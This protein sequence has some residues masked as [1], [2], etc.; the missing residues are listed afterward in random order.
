MDYL[1]Q[2]AESD[3]TIGFAGPKIYYLDRHTNGDVISFA[4]GAFNPWIGARNRGAGELDSGQYDEPRIVDYVEGSCFLVK[5]QVIH[6]TGLLDPT[7]F[8]YWEDVDWCMRGLEKGYKSAFFPQAKI[9]H[10]VSTSNANQTK[11]YYWTRNTFWFMNRK[12]TEVQYVA[13]L[14]YFF[15]IYM[16]S[17]CFSLALYHRD[18]ASLR[19][20]LK[21]VVDGVKKPV[22]TK[23]VRSNK[24]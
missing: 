21:G 20:F 22:R 23:T 7:Y 12:T 9:W 16:P 17:K 14:V 4:G 8:A 19:L 1:V 2:G 5:K 11:I 6:K 24:G 18:L 10:K 15:T 3:Q 13:F